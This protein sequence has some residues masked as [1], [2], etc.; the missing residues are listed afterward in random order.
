MINIPRFLVPLLL[1]VATAYAEPRF[2]GVISF[3]SSGTLVNYRINQIYNNSAIYTT[4]TIRVEVYGQYYP[5]TG[6]IGYGTFLYSALLDPLYPNYAYNNLTGTVAFNYPPSNYAYLVVLLEEY[7]V[8][9]Y[10]I[11]DYD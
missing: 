4:G 8:N 7:T 5:Y 10:I 9:G 11:K 2:N 6:G 3:G 1:L